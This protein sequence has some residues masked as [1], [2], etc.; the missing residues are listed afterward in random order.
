MS[1]SCLDFTR[2]LGDQFEDY[3]THSSL[4]SIDYK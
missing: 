3:I 1:D 2:D 4:A